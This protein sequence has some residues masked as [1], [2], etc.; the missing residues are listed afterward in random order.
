LGA[1]EGVSNG[2]ILGLLSKNVYNK[3]FWHFVSFIIDLKQ[4]FLGGHNTP[5]TFLPKTVAFSGT[6]ER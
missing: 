3:N 5:G 4:V 2:G 1:E 6:F